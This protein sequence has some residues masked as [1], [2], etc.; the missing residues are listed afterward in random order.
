MRR[1]VYAGS[2]DPLTNGH[3]DIIGRSSLIFD[4]L[5]VAV[6][7]NP[8]K[9]SLFSLEEREEIIRKSTQHLS[10]VKTAHFSGLLADF[11][12]FC[13]AQFIVRGL[14]NGADFEYEF[15]MA[16]LNRKLA[17]NVDTVFIAADP[18]QSFIS[19]SAVKEIASLG[20]SIREFVPEAAEEGL[21]QKF[22]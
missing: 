18:S 16:A 4:E 3:L 19:S 17:E 20:G 2:F 11:V 5:I 14:R 1:A 13:E 22:N 15:Q 12:N 21:R 6:V 10:N 7:H 8:N 9:K